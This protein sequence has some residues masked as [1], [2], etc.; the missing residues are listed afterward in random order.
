MHILILIYYDEYLYDILMFNYHE[1]KLIVN[2][3]YH[4]GII[5]YVVSH[6]FLK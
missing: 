3:L 6:K 4:F 1:I 2:L 5:V